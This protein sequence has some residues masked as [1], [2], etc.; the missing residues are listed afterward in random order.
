M[1]AFYGQF[2]ALIVGR[3]Y[4][5]AQTAP[6]E[7]V[8]FVRERFNPYDANAVGVYSQCNEK[9][10]HLPRWLA[11]V[12]APCMDSMR[13]E[14][15]GIVSGLGNEYATPVSVKLFA[16]STMAQSIRNLLGSYWEMW[17]LVAPTNTLCLDLDYS[18]HMRDEIAD[19][20]N[21]GSLVDSAE[22]VRNVLCTTNKTKLLVIS[23]ARGIRDWISYATGNSQK[24]VSWKIYT[25]DMQPHA[26]ASSQAVFANVDDALHV[27]T[28]TGKNYWRTI[29]VDITA[30]GKRLDLAPGLVSVLKDCAAQYV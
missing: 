3:R 29:A 23:T 13:C 21:S 2:S 18:A 10:G 15:G 28:Q 16:P 30:I 25:R 27:L 9:L 26:L 17:Q 14:L 8:G 22:L 19:G 12:L 20:G 24:T 7:H 1:L 6:S 5:N 11:A 4:Y